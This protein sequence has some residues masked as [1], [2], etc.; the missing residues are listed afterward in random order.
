MAENTG[1]GGGGP[2]KGDIEAL[3][4]TDAHGLQAISDTQALLRCTS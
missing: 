4:L 1:G 2:I 3:A